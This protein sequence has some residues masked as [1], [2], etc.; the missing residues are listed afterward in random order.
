MARK[1]APAEINSF[2]AGLFTDAS[3]LTFPDNA[4]LEENNMVLNIDG[5]RQRRLGMDLETDSATINSS[6]Q[7]DSNTAHT[8]YKWEN[9]G[10]DPN[11]SLLVVQFGN[12]LKFFDLDNS[13]ISSEVIHTETFSSVPTSNLFSY[14][15]VDGALVVVTG[16]KEVNTFSYDSSDGSIT[17][18][19]G[20]LKVRDLFGVEDIVTGVNLREGNDVSTRPGT[21]TDNHIYNLRNQ[22]WGV[23]R[24]NGNSESVTDPIS[25][26]LSSSS[27]YPSNADA[28]N[29]A[30]YPD[31][32]D[33][34]NRTIDRFFPNDLRDNP[35]G[36]GQSAQGHF[37][38]DALERGTSRLQAYS[39]MEDK[40]SQIS[41]TIS[42]LPL[43]KTPG[44]ASVVTQFAGRVWF[45][46]FSGDVTDGDSKSPRMSSYVLFSSLVED[47][48]DIVRCYQDGDPTSKDNPD[49]VETDGG[50]IRIDGAYGIKEMRSLQNSIIIVAQNGVWRITGDQ[51]SGFTA[52]GYT[53]SKISDRGCRGAK[54]VV[55]AEGT[56][57]YWGEDGIYTI[58]KNDLGDWTSSSL[59]R[60]RIQ[61]FYNDISVG[62]KILV[63]GYYDSY[64]KKVRWVY[65]NSITSTDDVRELV[66][67]VQLNAFYTNT[68]YTPDGETY[69]KVVGIFESNPY[70][71]STQE[72]DVAASSDLVLVGA[73]QVVINTSLRT[74]ITREVL[75]VVV[76]DNTSNISYTF[77]SYSNQNFL[78]WESVDDVG[79]DAAAYMV[80]GYQSGGEFQRYKQIPYLTVYCR[81]TEDGFTTDGNGDFVPTNQSSCKLQIQWEWTN[82]ASSNRWG[83]EFQA[84]RHKRLY[85][86]SGID[87]TYDD[88]HRVVV[89]KNKLRGKGRVFSF[90]F[91]TEPGKD[92][93]LY[94]WSVLAGIMTDV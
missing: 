94:G 66:F 5:S 48:S 39:D 54:S 68:I 70:T 79:V 15:V 77:S 80:T 52:T 4:S 55:E 3:P 61:N 6:V 72:E 25:A 21:K 50:F 73:E 14:A 53:V 17:L 36:I 30:L 8:S 38:I 84:Y 62:S 23:P 27:K 58:G 74:S 46:G 34:G 87:D 49:L 63:Q 40:Y 28:V 82:D 29:Q 35:L 78:D 89:T 76:L 9:A 47:T 11:K 86:P 20:V 42:D 69:P 22:S 19:T 18:S 10:G 59:T 93:H 43:D 90:K 85:F 24:V 88:G 64:E 83:R 91:S 37:I 26:F 67:D 41:I 92:L 60:G 1:L 12:E 2:V 65:N 32:N 45:G 81:K 71:L 56:L 7:A 57:F 33:S 75:Y 31:A 44:G 51:E 16:A 13:P